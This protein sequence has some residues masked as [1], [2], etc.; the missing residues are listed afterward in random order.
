MEEIPNN[1]GTDD[2]KFKDMYIP[3]VLK[4]SDRTEKIITWEGFVE[5]INNKIKEHIEGEFFGEDRQIGCYFV[6][7]SYL[8]TEVDLKNKN[9]KNQSKKFANKIIEYLWNDVAKVNK[10]EWFGSKYKTL[11]DAISGFK[12]SDKE[13][14]SDKIFNDLFGSSKAK[15]YNSESDNN[16]S[17]DEINN[18]QSTED[19]I[20]NKEEDASNE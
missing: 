9:Y 7:K 15:N 10:G 17:T 5:I 14:F 2:K 16:G 4:N 12:K 18:M 20:E 3:Y 13:L 6:N 8:C 19:A 11:S 1:F